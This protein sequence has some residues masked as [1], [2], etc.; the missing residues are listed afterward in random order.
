[1][2]RATVL[3]IVLYLL[4]AA[5]GHAQ[6]GGH[7]RTVVTPLE[8]DDIAKPCEYGMDIPSLVTSVQG[9]FVIFERGPQSHTF[10]NNPE[11]QSFAKDHQLAMLMP[12]HCA[13]RQNEDMDVDPAKGLGRA[14]FVALDQLAAETNHKELKVVPAVFLGFSAAG[15]LAARMPGVA[16]QRTVA[17]VVSHAGQS[18]PLGLNTIEFSDESLAVPELIIVGGKDRIVGT[19]SAYSY[20]QKYWL[21]GAPWLFAT[22]NEAGHCCTLD[23]KELILNW[24]DDV[25]SVRLK[26][27]GSTLQALRK[28]KGYYAFFQRV[29]TEFVDSGKRQILQ[30][31]TSPTFLPVT[32]T[33]QIGESVA[34]WLLSQKTGLQ[35][36]SFVNLPSSK[37]Q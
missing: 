6:P 35:W 10:Y 20:F 18:P 1:M 17:A 24:L 14:L 25:L 9:V 31:A 37:P 11:V 4:I 15:A 21:R 30:Q 5:Q 7:F 19:E 28:T 36:Q 16:P 2:K 32:D 29:P 33:L 23:A 12:L 34:G 26:S 3:P 8:G 22:Q 13:A 27:K